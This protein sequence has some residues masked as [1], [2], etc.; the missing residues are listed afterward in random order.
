LLSEQIGGSSDSVQS[1]ALRD[2]LNANLSQGEIEAL[3]IMRGP[4]RVPPRRDAGAD[5]RYGLAGEPHLQHVITLN[6][7]DTEE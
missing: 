7:K 2:W 3:R 5:A 6:T 1:A 4:L